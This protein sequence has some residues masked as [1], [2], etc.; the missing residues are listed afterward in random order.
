MQ[1]E[2]TLKPELLKIHDEHMTSQVLYYLEKTGEMP[3]GEEL[4]KIQQ[5]VNSATQQHSHHRTDDIFIDALTR[6]DAKQVQFQKQQ[7]M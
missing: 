5:R 2:T 6:E 7:Q 1:H 4:H 3:V